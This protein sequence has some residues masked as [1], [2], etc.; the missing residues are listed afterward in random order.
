AAPD[1]IEAHRTAMSAD[2]K[3][4]FLAFWKHRDV[5]PLTDVNERLGEHWRR[6]RRAREL[7]ALRSNGFGYFTTHDIFKERSPDLPYYSSDVVFDY[8]SRMPTWLDH[9]GMVY[10]RHGDADRYSRAS[11]QS[12]AE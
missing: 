1:E 7:Y 8:Q 10:V 6:L 9:R 5:F 12:R 2:R 4:F 11:D 3:E